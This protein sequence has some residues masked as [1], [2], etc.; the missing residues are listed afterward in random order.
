VEA[1]R[2]RWGLRDPQAIT[3]ATQHLDQARR[4]LERAASADHDT[5]DNLTQVREHQQRHRHAL[6]QTAPRRSELTGAVADLDAALEHTRPERVSRVAAQP[7]TELRHLLGDP[8]NTPAGRAVWSHYALIIETVRDHEPNPANS[9]WHRIGR[10]CADARRDIA[11]AD[12]ANPDTATAVD[13]EIWAACAGRAHQLAQRDH[14]A[15]VYAQH[16]SDR[17]EIDVGM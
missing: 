15:A 8:P 4:D 1:S 7:D 5:E 13:P 12:T 6:H 10:A 3:T 2:R 16:I 9:T 14:P 11:L 17:P